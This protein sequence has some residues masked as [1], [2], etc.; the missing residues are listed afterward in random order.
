[1]NKESRLALIRS[2]FKRKPALTEQASAIIEELQKEDADL[3][4]V[5][6]YGECLAAD[7]VKVSRIESDD[8]SE[9]NTEIVS[10]F[11]REIQQ[12]EARERKTF[13]SALA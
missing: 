3:G 13:E 1:M 7:N 9:A 5:A 10:P 12:E 2:A 4:G 6:S 8:E 11:M